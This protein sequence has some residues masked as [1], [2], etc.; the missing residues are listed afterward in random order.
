MQQYDAKPSDGEA[1]ALVLW[2]IRS[3]PTLPWLP[4]IFRPGVVAPDKVLSMRSN[5]T[6]CAN[7]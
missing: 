3:I 5:R 1:T 7:K 2:K 6:I 4:G